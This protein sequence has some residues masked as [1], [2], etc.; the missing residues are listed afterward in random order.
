LV[1]DAATERSGIAHEG[2]DL[3]AFEGDDIFA[4]ADGTVIA[5]NNDETLGGRHTANTKNEDGEY[6][7]TGP[8]KYVYILH[9]DGRITK[10]MHLS[11]ATLSP[12]DRVKAGDVIG[13]AGNT[14]GSK[15]AH[16][17]FEVHVANESGKSVP[18]TD[19]KYLPSDP[20]EEYPDVFKNFSL[21]GQEG[22]TIDNI[23]EL[24]KRLG[25]EVPTVKRAQ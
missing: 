22:I 5:S 20:F 16:L 18:G 4:I 6:I 9:D 12:G 10:S 8:G 24:A 2:I 21:K 23:P 19:G 17:H 15:A 3:R 7:G 13:A 25:L 11:N 1:T 14:G